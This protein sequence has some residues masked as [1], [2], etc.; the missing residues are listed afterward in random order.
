[1]RASVRA[2][3]HHEGSL[4]E[5]AALAAL[6]ALRVPDVV[7]GVHAG[8][9]DGL[10]AGL[11]ARR[12]GVVEV[13]AAVQQPLVEEHLVL[14]PLRAHAAREAL[15]VPLEPLRGGHA[16]HRVHGARDLLAAAGAVL[17][18]LRQV[19]LQAEGLL[20]LRVSA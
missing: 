12:E 3:L 5:D 9:L 11:A 4:E 15:G 2:H 13:L 20:V 6:E 10:A 18:E 19:V 7:H 16:V 1:M 8:A 17:A 14:E